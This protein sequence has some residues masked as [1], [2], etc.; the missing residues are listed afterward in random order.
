MIFLQRGLNTFWCGIIL[1][2]ICF[3]LLL[4]DVEPMAISRDFGGIFAGILTA[5]IGNRK[6]K[7]DDK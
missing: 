4:V 1:S 2:V 6:Q 5:I 7:K 3:L